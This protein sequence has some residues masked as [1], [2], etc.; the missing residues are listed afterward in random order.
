MGMF[1]QPTRR[2]FISG[3]FSSLAATTFAQEAEPVLDIHQHTHYHG[4]EDAHLIT[5][6]G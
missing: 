1:H 4:R 3:A 2:A 5:R 6:W